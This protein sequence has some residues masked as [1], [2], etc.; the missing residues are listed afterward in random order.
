HVASAPVASP[1]PP[2]L[3]DATA[4]ALCG[5]TRQAQRLI[6]DVRVRFPKDTLLRA[7]RIPLATAAIAINDGNPEVAIELL[8]SAAPYENTYPVPIYV[9]GLA[10]LKAHKPTEA[11][12]EFQKILNRSALFNEPIDALAR[13]GL[14]RAYALQGDTA[15]AR[16]K[17]QD[18]L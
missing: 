4:L 6:E 8:Q 1:S 3:G 10:Y 7:V 16:T 14:A 18:F 5:H 12:S 9:R 11:A 13:L 15:K 17:Y 2:V